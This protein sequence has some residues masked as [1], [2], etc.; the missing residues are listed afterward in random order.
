MQMSD[1]NIVTQFTEDIFAREDRICQQSRCQAPI[2]KGDPC[3]YVAAYDPAQPGKFV[4]GACY[5]LQNTNMSLVLPDP[6]SIHQ[7]VSAVQLR[8]SVNPPLILAMLNTVL[9]P[10]NLK[11]PMPPPLLPSSHFNFT[12]AH[13]PM[14]P[15]YPQFPHYPLSC[16]SF[17]AGPTMHSALLAT[18]E[19]VNALPSGSTD[20]TQ[21]EQWAH[22]TYHP[23]PAEMI[24]LEISAVF[25]T[26]GKRK[27]VQSNIISS[28]CEG[29]K[30]I[31]AQSNAHEVASIMLEN[32]FIVCDAKWVD[33]FKHPSSQPYFYTECLHPSNHKDSKFDLFIIISKCQWEDFE[34]F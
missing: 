32:E 23:P 3:H 16:V 26:V 12:P 22:M 15:S 18:L 21:H 19:H 17:L 4:C 27:N 11:A 25:E 7:S 30:D 8:A 34:T 6:Q 24:F 13:Q 29:L 20:Y 9:S 31:N 2:Q 28:I 1:K 10:S 33:F 5:R 14:S